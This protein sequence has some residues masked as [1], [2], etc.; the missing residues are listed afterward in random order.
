MA[1]HTL[2]PRSRTVH[3]GGHT[4]PYDAL[5]IA[6][7][8]RPRT[9]GWA[10][11]LAG[12]HLL[13]TVA[14]ARALRKSLA[15]SRRV[16]VVGGG[17]IGSEVASSARTLGLHVTIVEARDVPFAAALGE[18]AGR[19]CAALHR[20]HGTEL[21]CGVT[22]TALDGTGRVEKVLLSDGSVL[23]ADTVVVGVGSHPNTEWLKGS[24]VACTDG[25]ECD[26]ALRTTVPGVYAV[27]DVA[28]WFNPWLGRKVRVE[29]W[30]NAAHQAAA[31]ARGIATGQ[32]DTPPRVHPL[33]LERLVRPADP[34]HRRADRRRD[35]RRRRPRPGRVR[36]PLPHRRADHRGPHRGRQRRHRQIPHRHPPTR[37]LAGRPPHRPG[38]REDRADRR[39]TCVES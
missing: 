26:A 27:G 35:R 15:R 28:R 9:P 8:V 12:V 29:H 20:A 39:N 24:G 30:T 31:V 33:L 10:A 25:V 14:D 18:T 34:V 32:P 11:N 2:D 38:P 5:V 19:L 6:T 17:F 13:R 4:I 1:A 36:L 37:C 21:R 7:G 16:V 22:V 3:A 23:K